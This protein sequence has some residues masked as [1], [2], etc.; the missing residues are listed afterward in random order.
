MK[1]S[2]SL[3]LISVL[4]LTGC[5]AKGDQSPENQQAA[6]GQESSR[7]AFIMAGKVEAI[8]KADI[9]SKISGRISALNVDVGSVVKKGDVLVQF[10][11][12]DL[13]A[14]VKQAAAGV[15]T[16]NANLAKVQAGARPEQK[17]QAKALVDSTAKVYDNAKRSYD[18]ISQ[19]FQSGAASKQELEASEAQF[20]NAQA[21]YV[22]A[23][24]Q[25]AILS[26]GETKETLNISKSQV[27]QAKAALDV[28][29][30]QLSNGALV[31]PISGVVS[32]KNV[33]QGEYAASGTT[34]ISI[35]NPDSIYI[36]AYLPTRL[37]G[38][39]KQG[40]KA[41]IGLSEISGKL[42]DGEIVAVSPAVDPKSKSIQVRVKLLGKDSAI[43]VG[44]LAEIAL[45]K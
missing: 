41:I 28:A 20:K 17:T 19:L 44:M 26:S 34:L 22:S 24:S 32:V 33:N 40:Q 38:E 13:D 9:A 18:R 15:D 10:D 3:L 27:N 11:A 21:Q 29:K 30:A 1:K 36:N 16:A 39:V 31:A 45:K 12:K 42:F 43:K 4:M 25:Y 6:S 23:K 7:P 35:V 37:S 8:K 14:V 2:I 5:S